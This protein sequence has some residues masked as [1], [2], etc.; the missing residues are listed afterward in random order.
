MK[1]KHLYLILAIIGLTYTWYYNIQFYLTAEDTSILKFIELTKTTLPAKSINADISIVAVTFLIWM[2]YESR[3][4]KIKH[5][6]VIIPLTFL[7]AI[8]FSMP[9]FLYMHQNRLDQLSELKKT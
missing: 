4:L 1:F 5:W 7:V 3:R 8:A 6:W 2:T 9:L